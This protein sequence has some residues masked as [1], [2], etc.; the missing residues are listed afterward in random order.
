MSKG[1]TIIDKDYLRWVKELGQRYRAS[2]IKA[3][4]RVNE[5]LI[6]FYWSLGRDI[7]GMQA[8]NRY[9]GRFFATLSSDLRREMPGAEGF[10]ES[11]IRYAKR[12]YQLY[13]NI[14]QLVEE[15]PSVVSHTDTLVD[16]QTMKEIFP[17]VVEELAGVPWGHHRYIID[18][19][20]DAPE[21]ALFYV[22][23]TI[24]N[25]WSRSVLLN[26][27]DTDLH[28]R[29]GKAVTNFCRT[30]PDSMSD[31]AQELTRDPYCFAF[32]G[33]RERYNE[34][35]L[36]DALIANIQTMLLELGTGFAYMGREYRLQVGQ[37]EQFL[38]MLFYN[39]SL[40][41]YVV[42]EVKTEPFSPAHIGQLG[43]YVVAVDHILRKSYDNKTLGLLIC[44]TKDNV[45]AQ[46]ALEASN[47]PL[48]ISEYELS[49]LY[50]EKVE[51]TIPSI[52]EI[53]AR[54]S[55]NGKEERG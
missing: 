42:V 50:P 49:K 43:T 35:Q 33:L 52:E 21:T 27:L 47:Q 19:F 12:F 3:A 22:R 10:S 48:G 53:E 30:L 16:N 20:S 55:D 4:V 9:G 6:K 18:R 36:K 2:R 46:Y 5:E 8:E 28:K 40:R 51:G 54:L 17:Q 7:V 45:F 26:M 24:E 14:P 29:E 11:N 15:S 41:C 39:V 1:L 13:A 31:L 23:K 25:N 32:T 44:K 37:T 38:D 34:R